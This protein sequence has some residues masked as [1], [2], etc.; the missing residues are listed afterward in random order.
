MW[1][2]DKTV[3]CGD[4]DYARI[5]EH[6][7]A[8]KRGLV[9]V[10][11]IVMENH[12]GRLL[13]KEEV[14]HHRNHDRHDNRIEN[15]VLFPSSS[16]HNKMHAIERGRAMVLLRCPWCGKN[17]TLLKKNTFLIKKNAM[18]CSCCSLSCMAKLNTERRMGRLTD[19]HKKAIAQNV[20]FE[21]RDYQKLQNL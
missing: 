21:Y 16:S 6:P 13:T 12:L 9:A 19:E 14:V 17:F 1:E 20:V 2:Y 18:G 7:N 10:H 4:Y 15:L 8:T 5:P 3:K 11:R